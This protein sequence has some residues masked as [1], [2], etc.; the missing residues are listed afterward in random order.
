MT[1]E[2]LSYYPHKPK[3]NTVSHLKGFARIKMKTQ[4][5]IL[6]CTDLQV[7]S[8]GGKQWINFPSKK[9]EDPNGVKYIAYSRF[10]N[11]EESDAFSKEV[12]EALKRFA[13]QE[14]PKEV[15]L[16]PVSMSPV[17][18]MQPVDDLPF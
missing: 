14:K 10:E 11:Q 7:F 17:L 8:K 6:V 4:W 13:A 9:I 12:I 2:I 3:D 1:I 16:E 18:P 5:G 15:K